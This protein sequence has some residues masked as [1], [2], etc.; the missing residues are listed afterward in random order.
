MQGRGG[1]RQEQE[2]CTTEH[3]DTALLHTVIHASKRREKN[4]YL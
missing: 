3:A 2:Q 1:V 4:M